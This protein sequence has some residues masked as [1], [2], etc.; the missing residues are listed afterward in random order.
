MG[1]WKENKE[2][3]GDFFKNNFY[4]IIVIDFDKRR[5]IVFKG[6]FIKFRICES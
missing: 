3:V 5:F 6:Y 1:G 2:I 4:V